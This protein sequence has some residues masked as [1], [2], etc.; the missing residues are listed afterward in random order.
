M[1]LPT[2]S[3]WSNT[4]TN[5]PTKSGSRSSSSSSPLHDDDSF[6]KEEDA[7]CTDDGASSLYGERQSVPPRPP[8]SIR[9]LAALPAPSNASPSAMAVS[10]E[11]RLVTSTKI[12]HAWAE[13]RSTR[14]NNAVKGRSQRRGLVTLRCGPS[15]E[16]E[17]L[18]ALV[19][20]LLLLEPLR[21]TAHR[22]D[23]KEDEA[24]GGAGVGWSWGT[25]SPV[26]AVVVPMMAS[27]TTAPHGVTIVKQFTISTPT[28]SDAF[29]MV[30]TARRCEVAELELLP[31]PTSSTTVE[32]QSC[33]NESSSSSSPT[34]SPTSSFFLGLLLFFLRSSFGWF[35]RSRAD[36]PKREEEEVDL[37]VGSVQLST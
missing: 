17:P 27:S 9:Q 10:N 19:L 35:G 33:Q 12:N 29:R 3:T 28:T 31:P 1:R 20:L 15:E 25:P 11:A 37:G 13:A 4:A 24:M 14:S 32:R 36:V 6:A 18:V 5:A 8:P 16:E 26:A 23:E 7:P 2:S 21:H 22:S 34:S 30:N